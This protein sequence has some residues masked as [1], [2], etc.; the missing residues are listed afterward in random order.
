[1]GVAQHSGLKLG[2]VQSRCVGRNGFSAH[3]VR[4][5]LAAEPALGYD[6]A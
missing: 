1:M 4:R 2:R 6:N 3:W 5:R